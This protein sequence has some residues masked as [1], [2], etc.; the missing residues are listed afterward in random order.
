MTNEEQ[1]LECRSADSAAKH[2]RYRVANPSLDC[3]ASRDVCE[4]RAN[5]LEQMARA[6][7][8]AYDRATMDPAEYERFARAAR[9]FL[10]VNGPS[11]R[12]FGLGGN[13]RCCLLVCVRAER[14]I[15]LRR[16][17]CV[18]GLRCWLVDGRR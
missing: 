10:L 9:G 5:Q 17:A 12:R 15:C 4:A 3:P 8:N 14:C 2:A 1:E 18:N 6:A 16:Q 11:A 13:P 7:W